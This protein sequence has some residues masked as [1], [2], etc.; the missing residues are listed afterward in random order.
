[1]TLVTFDLVSLLGFSAPTS[2]KVTA[3]DITREC[4]PLLDEDARRRVERPGE[5]HRRHALAAMTGA[6]LH[7]VMRAPVA[8]ATRAARRHERRPQQRRRVGG[9]RR[10][11]GQAHRDYCSASNRRSYAARTT[12]LAAENRGAL[13]AYDYA[14]AEASV[15]TISDHRSRLWRYCYS[16]DFATACACG[17]DSM[18]APT[19]STLV[20]ARRKSTQTAANTHCMLRA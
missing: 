19:S 18:F 7:R 10:K 3:Q 6:L 9:Q 2:G 1:M 13:A 20:R 8:G 4:N 16:P 14:Q 11:L 12:C 15:T 17:V 5:R